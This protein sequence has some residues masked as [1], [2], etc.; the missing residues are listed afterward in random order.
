M[1]RLQGLLS[2][3]KVGVRTGDRRDLCQ[4][5]V[6]QC[7]GASGNEQQSMGGAVERVWTE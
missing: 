4:G 1:C 7:R 2:E 6:G 5:C 3:D